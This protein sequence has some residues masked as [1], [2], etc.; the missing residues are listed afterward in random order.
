MS[1]KPMLAASNLYEVDRGR[2]GRA[3]DDAIA[4][5]LKDCDERPFLQKKRTITVKLTFE[6]VAIDTGLEMVKIDPSVSLVV[7][8]Q[9]MMTERLSTE[10]SK[11]GAGNTLTFAMMPTSF[12]DNMFGE[13]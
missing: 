8:A 4:Q 3:I 11:D 1:D 6:P 7:P 9:E 13:E 10:N 12:Q 5:V 2:L